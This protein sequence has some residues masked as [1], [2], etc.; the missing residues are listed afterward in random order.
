MATLLVQNGTLYT[1]FEIIEDGAVFARNGLIEYAGPRS[2]AP[3]ESGE[4]L[5][6]GGR[7]ICPG[8]ID[9]QVNGGRGALLTEDPTA[10]TV[11]LMAQTYVR[12]GTTAIVPTVVTS[13]QEQMER[14]LVA[15][16]NA[17]RR[18]LDGARVLG[19]HL[20]GPFISSKRRGAH[21]ERY[22]RQPDTSALQRLLGASEGTLRV[23]TLA[24]E[25]A[26]A[27]DLIRA[28]REA[29]VVVSIG[30]SD[31]TFEQ[32]IAGIE[33]GATMAT[34]LFNGM[35]PLGHRDP[36]VV[37]AVLTDD[38]VT[39]GVIPDGVHVDPAVLSL[40]ARAKG[41]TKTALVTDA[42][43]I[44]VAESSS[45]E[46]YGQPVEVRNGACYLPDGTLAGSALTMDRAVW[47]MH[48]LAKAPLRE[49]IEMATA[50]PARVLGLEN[51]GVLKAAVQADV[52]IFD[53]ELRPW[54]VYVGGE[55]AYAV[56]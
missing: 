44:V 25:L 56:E 12:F 14:G 49:A 39:A 26:G 3:R 16:A 1:P 24:P 2:G 9:L 42:M 18:T 13:S 6:A 19:S 33:A 15:V 29:G 51:I 43:S 30:H 7:I 48:S 31:A 35:R 4:T 54:R 32:A 46:I 10:E 41:P 21:A 52:A 5:D 20:E 17:M 34:H 8:L 38:R 11:D 45:F 23:I 27:L 53:E 36:G 22:L 28:A 55:L 40:I 37:G 47:N 50:T